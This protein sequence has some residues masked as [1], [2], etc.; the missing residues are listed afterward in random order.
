[1]VQTMERIIYCMVCGKEAPVDAERCLAC[2]A[3][4]HTEQQVTY[5]GLRRRKFPLMWLLV[6]LALAAVLVLLL[7]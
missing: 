6:A 3:P 7:A 1:M 4:L 2:D 5:P